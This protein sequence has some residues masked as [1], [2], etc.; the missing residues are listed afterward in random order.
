MPPSLIRTP[1]GCKFRPRCPHA[2]DK[3]MEE[4]GLDNRVEEPGHLDRC[5]LPV[6]E[7]RKLRDRTIAGEEAA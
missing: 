2:F 4:P 5:W 7:K 3:C 6:A 1:T